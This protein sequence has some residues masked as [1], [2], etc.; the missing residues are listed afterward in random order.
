MDDY[1]FKARQRWE[2]GIDSLSDTE[3]GRLM[4]SIWDF[5]R[6]GEVA[7]LSGKEN[8]VYQMIIGDLLDD[9]EAR[10]NLSETRREAANNRWNKQITANNANASLAMQGHANGSNNS[11]NKSNS[12]SN[13]NS[14]S[15][16]GGKVL[17]AAKF[18]Q[19]TYTD[20]TEEMDR[21][22]EE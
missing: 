5:A 4:K 12:H 21:M 15:A 1:Y 11:N 13:S 19:R 17:N 6:T 20:D 14:K 2:R 3:A 16:C 18:T 9:A 10:K 7:D 8:G 22:M